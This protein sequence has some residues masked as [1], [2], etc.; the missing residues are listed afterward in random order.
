MACPPVKEDALTQLYRTV[1]TMDINE[2]SSRDAAVIYLFWQRVDN[3]FAKCGFINSMDLY[4]S[5]PNNTATL[6]AESSSM[7]SSGDSRKPQPYGV[8]KVKSSY[9]VEKVKSILKGEAK[10]AAKKVTGVKQLEDAAW[11][12][13]IKAVAR[14][15][16]RAG[17]VLLG[18]KKV[19]KVLASPIVL[20]ADI[21]LGCEDMGDATIKPYDIYIM[22]V[23]SGIELLIHELKSK[24]VDVSGLSS[25]V[26]YKAHMRDVFGS[27]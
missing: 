24:G 19:S 23:R 7:L 5:S 8:K 16:P 27:S 13:V 10:S 22:K 21:V 1:A 20:F 14:K 4:V 25:Q 11:A 9:E 18:L 17:K 12:K 15:A 3:D 2:M 6:S 26:E